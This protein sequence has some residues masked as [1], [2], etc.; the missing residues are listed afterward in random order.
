MRS[1]IVGAYY[2]N[3]KAVRYKTIDIESGISSFL[4]KEVY[5]RLLVEGHD[6][7]KLWEDE[8]EIGIPSSIEHID[9]DVFEKSYIEKII[10]HKGLDISCM[11]IP[12]LVTVIMK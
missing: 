1:V 12:G 11:N 4:S 8:E 6:I 3:R 5:E 9:N 2:K 7:Q 10:V